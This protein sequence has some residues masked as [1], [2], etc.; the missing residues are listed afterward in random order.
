VYAR[1]TVNGKR[2]EFSLGRHVEMKKWDARSAKLRGTTIAVN[3]FNRFLETVKYRLY[4]IYDTQLKE[5][6]DVSAVTI[7]NIYLGKEGKEYTVLEI[8]GEHNRE[9]ESLLGK[10][11]TKGTLQ[12]YKAAYK[13]LAA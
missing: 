12:R 13:H 1:L 6:N 11:Y 9:M 7:K 3:N 4:E 10:D 5:K 2:A 8:F